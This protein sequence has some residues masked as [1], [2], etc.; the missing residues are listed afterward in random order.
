[1]PATPVRPGDLLVATVALTDPH[2]ADSVVLVLDVA[3]D[4]VLGV[5]LNHPTHVPVA[6]HL[7]TW[8]DLMSVPQMLFNGG[9]VGRDGAL[10]LG[11][12]RDPQSP[13]DGWRPVFDTIGIVDLDGTPDA[14]VAGLSNLRVFAGYAGWGAEQLPEEIAEGAWYVAPGRTDDV[15]WADPDPLRRAVLRRQPGE[16]AWASTRPVDPEMN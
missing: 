12:V 7:P 5:V 4:G 3:E 6:E 15:F 1:M 8:A 14:V 13:P 2:F 9:P 10:A 11:E 16:L